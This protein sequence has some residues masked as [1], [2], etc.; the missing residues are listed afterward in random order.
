MPIRREQGRFGELEEHT[1]GVAGFLTA[2]PA[3]RCF[4]AWI[5][6]ETA[7]PEEAR[8]IAEELVGADLEK[9][10]FDVNWFP[11]TM[12]LAEVAA[13]LDMRRQAETLYR[14]MLPYGDRSPM[15]GAVYSPGSI[16]RYLGM[17]A[18]VLGR[19]EDSERHFE[20]AIIHNERIGARPWTAHTRCEY[21][22]MLHER[23]A[24]GD[25]ERATELAGVALEE[26]RAL[27]MAHLT[28]AVLKLRLA[29][30][31]ADPA[32]EGSIQLVISSVQERRPDLGAQAAPDGTVTLMFS[33]M[34]GFTEMTERLGDLQAREVIRRH[35]RIVRQQ[36][37][38]HG[39]YEVELQGDGFLLAFNSARRA[40]QCAVAIQ[41]DFDAHN[42]AEAHPIR[43]R[44]GLHT[45]EAL[46]DAEKFFGRTVILASRI[47][48]QAEGGQILVS[49]LLKELT[50]SLGD[51]RF[52]EVR[53]FALKGIAEPQELALVD[54]R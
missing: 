42:Q 50:R 4:L 7:R 15:V 19:Y 12:A 1:R 18:R 41:R 20:A 29:Q 33:D 32:D 35:N 14:R 47:A 30:Q 36:L 23:G 51:I 52:G 40:L 3:W 31:G 22:R 48:A 2:V 21:A 38:A 24:P 6:V 39:G 43:V 10:P 27:G 8:S 44:I 54:W 28:Q 37:A 11:C 46:R 25:R 16:E 49:S 5:L 53:T 9:L 13:H 26:A 34:Q 45:G 17:L